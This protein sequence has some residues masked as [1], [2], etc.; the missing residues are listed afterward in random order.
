MKSKH[1]PGPW[2]IRAT[3]KSLAPI[4][5]VAATEAGMPSDGIAFVSQAGFHAKDTNANAILIAAAPELLKSLIVTLA[6]LMRRTC[7]GWD[8]DLDVMQNL[9]A[10]PH[11][12]RDS[13]RE[14]FEAIAKARGES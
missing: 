2:K 11:W 5:I 13:N 7:Q 10:A 1:T 8:S 3:G 4:E 9:K 6:D 14:A 12:F